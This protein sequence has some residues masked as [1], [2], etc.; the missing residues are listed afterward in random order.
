MT[1]A[2]VD[3]GANVD[4]VYL[5][6]NFRHFLLVHLLQRY[7]FYQLFTLERTLCAH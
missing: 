7:V 6:A 3:A 1:P 2:V 4:A 5:D